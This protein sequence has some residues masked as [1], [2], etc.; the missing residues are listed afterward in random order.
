MD[1]IQ[2]LDPTKL[3][4]AG[5]TLSFVM[6]PFSSPPYNLAIFLFGIYVSESS[7]AFLA[8]Q[9]LTVLL[10]AS[11]ITDFIWMLKNNQYGFIKFLTV[12]L[13]LL[14]IPTFFAFGLTIRERRAQHGIGGLG[15]RGGDINGPTIWSMPGGFTSAPRDGYQTVEDEPTSHPTAVKTPSGPQPALARQSE[16]PPPAIGSYQNV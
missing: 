15:I 6:S 11:A 2:S 7:E 5:T 1:F 10:G 12:L 8:V 3:I 4:L 9:A 16:A 14:K 13:L